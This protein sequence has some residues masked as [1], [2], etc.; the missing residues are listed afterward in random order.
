MVTKIRAQGQIVKQC[1]M[2]TVDLSINNVPIF[3]PDVDNWL[4]PNCNFYTVTDLPSYVSFISF[5]VL[6]INIRSCR[7]NFSHFLAHFCNVLS[8]FTCIV[9][10]ETWLTEDID[11]VF[12]IP[13]YYCFNLY[14]NNFGGGLKLYLKNGVQGRLL[15]SFTF[16]ND[17]FEMLTVEL[18]FGT[19]KTVLCCCYHP[20]TSSIEHNNGFIVSLEHFLSLLNNL[21]VPVILAGDLNI[22]LLNSGCMVYVNT[23]I[24][25]MFELGF[26]PVITAPTKVNVDNNITRFSLIDHIWISNTTKNLMSCIFPLDITDHFPVSAFLKFPF[27]PSIGNKDHCYRSLFQ[28][29]KI[30]FSVLLSNTILDV[31]PNSLQATYNSYINKV[32]DCYNVAFPIRRRTEKGKNPAPWMTPQLMQCIRKKSKLYKLYLKGRIERAEYIIFRNRL[33]SLIRRVKRLYYS[34]LL[35]EAANDIKQTWSCLNNI[36]ERNVQPMLRELKTGNVILTGRDLVNYV[37]NHFINAVNVITA[38]LPRVPFNHFLTTAVEASCFFYPTTQFEVAKVIKGLKNKGNKLLDIHPSIVKENIII[39]SIHIA[40]LYNLS[41]VYS[42]FP[43]KSKIGRVNPIHKSGPIDNIDN[44]RPISVLPIFSKIFEKLTFQRMVSFITQFNI[45]SDC[46]FG[47]RS[48][49]STTQAITKLLSYI[50]PA[51]HNKTY[52]AC[53]FLDLK[54]AFDTVDHGILIKKLEH[55]G[56]RGNCTDYLKSYYSNRKQYVYMDG[57]ESDML[58]II[59]GVPQGSII[60]PLCFS[61]F[62]NDLPL[63]VDVETVLFADDAAFII[64]SES[65]EDLYSKIDKLFSDLTLYLSRNRLIAN[66]S[67]SKLMLFNSRPT[68]NLPVLLFNN[69]PI[70]WIEEFKYLGLIITNKLSFTRHINRVSLNISRLTGVFT[71]LRSIVPQN[72]MF[73]VYYGLV[74]PHLINHVVV[75][76]SAPPSHLRILTTRL[77]NMLRV[78]LGVRWVNGRPNM[79]TDA[80]YNENNILKIESIFKLSLFKLLKS[81][82][83]GNLPDMFE[84]LLAPHLSL[85][86]YN[87]RHGRFR[88]PALTCEVE[89]RSLPHQL[90]S[91]YERLPDGYIEQNLN[92][93]VKNFKIYLLETQ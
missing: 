13:G 31:V 51:Y 52:C 80:M 17:Y 40:E 78:I 21:R 6:M 87:T 44:Y 12:N 64:K 65:L 24:N 5:S 47:F 33:T 16:I 85:R 67:K 89:R 46:Q 37:N 77:N 49:R 88:H 19:N 66:A 42:E 4:Q 29:G 71:N 90:I 56:F 91:L 2:Q 84:Y 22:N 75:W 63:A 30:T 28:R 62:I 43:D 55:Y 18:I 74:Y 70:D 3:V 27:E 32:L 39:F 58:N 25:T 82:L 36:M 86:N 81:L 7:K 76:G 45:L 11:N 48:G 23:F 54:K 38:N 1:R 73:K 69:N 26:S 14:R 72:I 41:L 35:F 79:H 34:R 59:H 20:P 57:I 50:L 60:G 53:F 9:F 10:T 83:D 93:A 8:Y 15:D 61:L 68:R 92:R